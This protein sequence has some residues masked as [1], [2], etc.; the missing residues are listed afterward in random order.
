MGQIVGI[1]ICANSGMPMRSVLSANALEKRGL[2]G[3]RYAESR[4]FYS[5]KGR[6][7]R[8][9]VTLIAEEDIIAGN[10]LLEVPF[11]PEDTRRNI[12]TSGVDLKT[13]VNIEFLVRGEVMMLVHARCGT[14]SRPRLCARG[15]IFEEHTR[16]T[17]ALFA[18]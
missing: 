17:A 9:N 10:E 15:L 6:I 5:G 18:R 13:L 1:Y 4:G 14:C 12:V 8:R 7:A 2:E 11:V 16:A 3:D